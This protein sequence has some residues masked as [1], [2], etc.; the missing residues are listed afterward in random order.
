MVSSP[1]KGL[2]V[3]RPRGLREEEARE[4]TIYIDR[5]HGQSKWALQT[6]AGLINNGEDSSPQ[7]SAPTGT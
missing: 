7:E 3:E 4:G 5:A 1:R 2:I 6:K